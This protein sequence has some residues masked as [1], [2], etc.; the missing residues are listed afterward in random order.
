MFKLPYKLEGEQGGGG[1][2]EESYTKERG[3][4]M[5]PSKSEDK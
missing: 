5:G 4:R 1:R 2:G 3:N